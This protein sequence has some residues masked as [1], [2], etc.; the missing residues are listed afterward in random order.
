MTL[1]EDKQ[2]LGQCLTMILCK[3]FPSP[4]ALQTN[5]LQQSGS[6][7]AESAFYDNEKEST[8]KANARPSLDNKIANPVR[9]R[10]NVD[11]WKSQVKDGERA[12][13]DF[14]DVI[15]QVVSTWGDALFCDVSVLS[16]ALREE[17]R[18]PTDA[19]WERRGDIQRSDGR[20]CHRQWSTKLEIMSFRL[21]MVPVATQ[22]TASNGAPLFWRTAC[23]IAR[24][25]DNKNRILIRVS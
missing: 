7:F 4:A 10:K 19:E 5:Y 3:Y 12:E 15:I 8:K 13:E 20:A 21:M 6:S 16:V 17:H 22:I 24:R 1:V 18:T 11:R 23:A 25:S 14:A 2:L 9:E